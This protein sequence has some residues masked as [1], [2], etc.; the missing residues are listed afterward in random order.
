MKKLTREDIQKYGT[1]KERQILEG[2]FKNKKGPV[3]S[4]SSD[5]LRVTLFKYNDSLGGEVFDIDCQ[6]TIYCV[7]ERSATETF[8]K[9]RNLVRRA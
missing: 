8:V 2:R 6:G 9:L 3:D 5:D 1:D 4:F 7:D